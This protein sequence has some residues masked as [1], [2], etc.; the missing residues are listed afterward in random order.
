MI[1]IA[2]GR[3]I[4][5]VCCA[6]SYITSGG[7]LK[8]KPTGANLSKVPNAR[9]QITACYTLRSRAARTRGRKRP[10][11]REQKAIDSHL[12]FQWAYEH[13]FFSP[14]NMIRNHSFSTSVIVFLKF[15]ILLHLCLSRILANAA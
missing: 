13:T 12:F 1:S 4:W 15:S 14:N 6:A 9:S 3:T 11:S 7:Y 8:S 2:F 5:N 10:K